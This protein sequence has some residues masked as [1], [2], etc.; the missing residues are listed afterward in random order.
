M[1]GSNQMNWNVEQPIH[2][3]CLTFSLGFCIQ[4]KRFL[5]LFDI[6][7]RWMWRL[8]LIKYFCVDKTTPNGVPPACLSKGKCC[9]F[10]VHKPMKQKYRLRKHHI[11]C[12]H[13]L[14]AYCVALRFLSSLW[15]ISANI[16]QVDTLL[17]VVGTR[18]GI[19]YDTEIKKYAVL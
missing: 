12:V 19:L 4:F 14:G 8:R 1:K 2:K 16:Y 15:S 7:M 17:L 3:I 13:K 11:W 10:W 9:I 18:F 6:E 5:V